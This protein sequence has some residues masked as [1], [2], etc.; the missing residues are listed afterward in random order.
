MKK[1]KISHYR[2]VFLFQCFLVG[3]NYT[4]V[5]AY[6]EIEL[7]S[8][9]QMLYTLM[10]WLTLRQYM[11]ERRQAILAEGEKYPLEPVTSSPPVSPTSPQSLSEMLSKYLL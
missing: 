2:C 5:T 10:F 9:L 3:R 8:H 1:R 6:V 11:R 7:H 4:T